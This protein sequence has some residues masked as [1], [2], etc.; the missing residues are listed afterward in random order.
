MRFQ[1]SARAIQILRAAIQPV[2]ENVKALS[3]SDFKR[4]QGRIS[5][6]V[7]CGGR[8]SECFAHVLPC[9]TILPTQYAQVIKR[10]EGGRCS[11][12]GSVGKI[13]PVGLKV[14]PLRRKLVGGDL[15]AARQTLKKHVQMFSLAPG[16]PY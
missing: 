14:P 3:R 2:S 9:E 12:T 7:R 16:R 10:Q 1:G 5:V 15:G 8:P 4:G 6:L 11:D 13:R